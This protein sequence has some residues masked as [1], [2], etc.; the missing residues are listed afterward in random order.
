MARHS[1]RERDSDFGQA[2][3][4]LRR[5]HWPDAARSA[6]PSRRDAGCPGFRGARSLPDR[7]AATRKHG[8]GEVLPGL[9]FT[10]IEYAQQEKEEVEEIQVERKRA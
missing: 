9:V 8:L 7:A 5:K 3:F 6:F 10:A 1:F 2:M 4:K